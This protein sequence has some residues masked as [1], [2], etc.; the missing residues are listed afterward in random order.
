MPGAPP[1]TP[2]PFPISNVNRWLQLAAVTHGLSEPKPALLILPGCR[3][4]NHSQ[5]Q[6]FG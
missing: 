6:I 3:G 4:C 5:A 1:H 2:H